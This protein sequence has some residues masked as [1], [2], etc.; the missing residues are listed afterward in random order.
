MALRL[1]IEESA[2]EELELLTTQSP[3]RTHWAAPLPTKLAKMTRSPG[4]AP[5]TIQARQVESL[6]ALGMK[7]SEIAEALLIEEHLLRFYYKRELNLGAVLVNAKVGQVALKMA[8]S[9]T[10]PEMTKFWLKSRAGWKETAVVENKVEIKHEVAEARSKL[11]G[12]RP[13]TLENNT[14]EESTLQEITDVELLQE[15]QYEAQE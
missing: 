4:F 11:L 13:M 15:L 8:L 10:D 5:S 6:V 12:T 3:D 14:G 2:L 1:M 9:G 7:E